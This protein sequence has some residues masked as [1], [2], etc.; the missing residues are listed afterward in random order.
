[1]HARTDL[2]PETVALAMALRRSSYLERGVAWDHRCGNAPTPSAAPT[3]VET[4]P[5]TGTAI[6]VPTCVTVSRPATALVSRTPQRADRPGGYVDGLRDRDGPPD[7]D[8][9]FH[10]A[11]GGGARARRPWEIRVNMSRS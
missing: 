6:A 5:P 2:A 8:V 11:T 4:L 3:A 1:M 10:A 9:K 7:A